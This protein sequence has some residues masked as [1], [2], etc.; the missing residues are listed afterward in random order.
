M[1]TIYENKLF[2]FSVMVFM[3]L[4]MIPA[5]AIAANNVIIQGG[6]IFTQQTIRADTICDETGANC[7]DVSKKIMTSLGAG[8][9]YLWDAN[10]NDIYYISGF[11]GIGTQTPAEMLEV[12]GNI[13]ANDDITADIFYG[14]GSGLTGVAPSLTAG[15]A[16]VANSLATNPATGLSTVN[17]INA[18]TGII[19]AARLPAGS[20]FLGNTIGTSEIEDSAI[21]PA[22][23]AAGSLYPID[24]SGTAAIA[25][26]AVLA[27]KAT[28][29][30]A[31]ASTGGSSV[32]TAINDATTTGTILAS[33]L[34]ANVGTTIETAEI[35]DSAVTSA[36]IADA[37]IA[38]AD[39]AN[40][41][42]TSAKVAAGNYNIDISGVANSANT[43]TSADTVAS[44][45]GSSL[46]TA[47]NAGTT[48]GTI[49]ANRLPANVGTTIETAEIADSAV[50]SAKIADATIAT[51]DIADSAVTSAKIADAT[52]ANADIAALAITPAK[53]AAGTYSI[54][55]ATANTITNDATAGDSVINAINNPLTTGIISASRL[56]GGSSFLGNSIGTSEIE[57]SAVTSAKIADATITTA[58]IADSAVTSAKI[59]DATI[60]TGDIANLAITPAKVATGTYS[61]TATTANAL[62]SD[63]TNCASGYATGVDASGNA[64]G[65]GIVD[66][67]SGFIIEVRALD[68]AGPAQGRMWL[69]N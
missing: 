48:L 65:C 67:S 36:K 10:G 24:I 61:I 27:I 39:I 59:A 13:L 41:A 45:A 4:I 11:V 5:T 7:V 47:I 37:T 33:R 8:G 52:I 15:T 26:S 20:S 42:I 43:A 55:A 3:I 14:S 19:D 31:V 1:E 62:V 44:T 69:I 53:V 46:I 56:P 32:I 68:P 23:V 6:N 66:A 28:T 49:A 9:T 12:N 58:D 29:A 35:A 63:G 2:L 50:T 18:G 21:T 30:D 16:T 60:A 22:K 64:Q 54:T 25:T 51:A 40:L 34:P 38:T 17:A 57:D